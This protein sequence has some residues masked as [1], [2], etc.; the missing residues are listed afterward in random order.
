MFEMHT[1]HKYSQM[2]VLIFMLSMCVCVCVCACVCKS[3]NVCVGIYID[4][5]FNTHIYDAK[6]E[7]KGVRHSIPHPPIYVPSYC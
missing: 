1:I 6:V 2:Y 3:V 7:Q 4:K 5:I